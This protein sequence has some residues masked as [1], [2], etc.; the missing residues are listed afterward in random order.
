LTF[1]QNLERVADRCYDRLELVE[2][3]RDGARKLA[4]ELF[5]QDQTRLILERDEARDKAERYRLEAN[6]LMMQRDEARNELL[7]CNEYNDEL[8]RKL[9]T[10]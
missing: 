1:S 8:Y 5:H 2:R 6:A 3:E 9:K 4:D 7:K 10:R